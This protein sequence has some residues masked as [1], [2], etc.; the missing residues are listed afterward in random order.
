MECTEEDLVIHYLMSACTLDCRATMICAS[1]NM[2][3]V[4]RSCNRLKKNSSSL[5]ERAIGFVMSYSKMLQQLLSFGL[6]KGMYWW[7]SLICSLKKFSKYTYSSYVSLKIRSISMEWLQSTYAKAS[8]TDLQAFAAI[9]GKAMSG[10][11]SFMTGLKALPFSGILV[12]NMTENMK[13]ISS[14]H[15]KE[16]L[17]LPKLILSCTNPVLMICSAQCKEEEVEGSVSDWSSDLDIMDMSSDAGSDIQN[18]FFDGQQTNHD[19][20]GV[21]KDE[22]IFLQCISGE[23]SAWSDSEWSSDSEG[24]TDLDDDSEQLWNSFFLNDPYNPL[25]F[26]KTIGGFQNHEEKRGIGCSRFETLG[27]WEGSKCKI[28][29]ADGESETLEK[30]KKLENSQDQRSK[31]FKEVR[32][33]DDVKVHRMI[34]WDYAYRAARKG[35]WEQYARDRCRFQRRIKETEC[36]IGYCF[37]PQY[38]EKAWRILQEVQMQTEWT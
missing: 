6:A 8:N 22:H 31:V 25:C 35:P 27:D 17:E 36:A 23:D 3:S 34:A 29:H 24:D 1:S 5:L 38:R 21:T 37:L 20:G 14:S 28:L 11:S 13:D 33:S 9:Q 16:H 26:S 18:V 19:A 4:T 10:S 32:F 7:N 12:E 2:E 15:Q 30:E